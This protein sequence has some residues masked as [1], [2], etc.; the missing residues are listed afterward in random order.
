MT[1]KE[2]GKV[3]ATWEGMLN[4]GKGKVRRRITRWEREGRGCRRRGTSEGRLK[5]RQMKVT[6]SRKRV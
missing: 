1:M 5:N 2:K 6:V 4:D 3:T